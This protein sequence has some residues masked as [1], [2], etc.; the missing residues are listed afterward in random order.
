V[1]AATKDDAAARAAWAAWCRID[2]GEDCRRGENRWRA[3]QDGEA[4]FYRAPAVWLHY[5]S[6]KTMH[7]HSEPC[8]TLL[9]RGSDQPVA[10]TGMNQIRQHRSALAWHG[11][12]PPRPTPVG[13]VRCPVSS[14]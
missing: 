13:T 11:T 3:Y 14:G 5:G 12:V 8:F 6:E 2:Q 1:T 7:G 9:T 10:G 4:P